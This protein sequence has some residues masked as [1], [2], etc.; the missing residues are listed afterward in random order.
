[1]ANYFCELPCVLPLTLSPSL[2]APL[3]TLG[4]LLDPVCP[5]QGAEAHCLALL[6]LT[7]GRDPPPWA[8]SL[9]APTP[10][11]T[12]VEHPAFLLHT[13]EQQVN[14]RGFQLTRTL[15]AVPTHFPLI[16][17]VG[18]LLSSPP[19]A[20]RQD[21]E[22]QEEPGLLGISLVMKWEAQLSTLSTTPA[23]SP[24]ACQPLRILPSP[25]SPS[26]VDISH[27]RLLPWRRG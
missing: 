22:R 5:R 14:G 15:S 21:E 20:R 23:L 12:A 9:T 18:P 27:S 3:S 25:S 1:M 13:S 2:P 6:E 7:K 16:S 10:F 19:R 17:L 24:E 26:P 11:P 4:V 8:S